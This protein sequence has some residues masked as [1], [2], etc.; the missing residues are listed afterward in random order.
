MNNGTTIPNVTATIS[1][2]FPR[3]AALATKFL[4]V[5]EQY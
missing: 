4:G 2:V 3:M 5:S 1:T